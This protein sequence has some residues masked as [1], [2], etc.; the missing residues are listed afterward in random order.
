MIKTSSIVITLIIALFFLG[1]SESSNTAPDSMLQ[2]QDPLAFA[3][4]FVQTVQG[5]ADIA[6][7]NKFMHA[8]GKVEA[9]PDGKGI[10]EFFLK[11][12]VSENEYIEKN[13]LLD[14]SILRVDDESAS[15]FYDL[16]QQI[17]YDTVYPHSPFADEPG[18]VIREGQILLEKVDGRWAIIGHTMVGEEES[19]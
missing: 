15:I 17:E 19:P 1:C 18:W 16:P 5:Q 7:Y 12:A 11:N 3:R 8:E 9:D 13:N 4:Y 14:S 6:T 2:E 10:G